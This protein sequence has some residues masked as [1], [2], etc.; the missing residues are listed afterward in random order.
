[1]DER[2]KAPAAEPEVKDPSFTHLPKSPFVLDEFT[3]NYANGDTP[4]VVLPYLWEHL[5]KDGWSLWHAEHRFPQEF[6]Q[7]F[8]SCNLITGM[9]QPLD[10]LRENA[11]LGVI[12]FGTNNS[13]SVYSIWVSGGQELAFLL[14]SD[15]Q[16]DNESYIWQKLDPGIEETQ[17]LV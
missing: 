10:K 15:W 13:S 14:S 11:F 4:P 16:E 5:D 8:M 17:A 1:M 12:L 9:F 6:T 2:E 7:T 3:H